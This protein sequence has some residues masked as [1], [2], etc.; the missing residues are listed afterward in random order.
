MIRDFINGMSFLL[1]PVNLRNRTIRIKS[2]ADDK[3]SIFKDWEKIGIDMRR[4]IDE[5]QITEQSTGR[6]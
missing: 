5:Y 3:K 2:F 6:K 4:A 1:R